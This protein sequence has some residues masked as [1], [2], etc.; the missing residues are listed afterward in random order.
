MMMTST[1]Y[2]VLRREH[3]WPNHDDVYG[4]HDLI[5]SE[6]GTPFWQK[7]L[8]VFLNTNGC[9]LSAAPHAYWWGHTFPR[10][11]FGPARV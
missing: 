11:P 6:K 10:V 2:C 7:R 4:L 3:P 1:V 8:D 9:D 5:R